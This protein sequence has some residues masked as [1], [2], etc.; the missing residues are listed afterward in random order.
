MKS[1][2]IEERYKVLNSEEEILNLF[3]KI[4]DS[5]FRQNYHIQ[6]ITGLLSD[7]NGFTFYNNKWH[8]FYQW[9]PW[10]AVHGLKYWYHVTSEDLVH[11]KNEGIGIKPDTFYDNKGA[12]SGSAFTDGNNLYLFY[13]GNHRDEDWVRTPYSCLAIYNDGKLEKLEEPLFGPR[14][15]YTEHQRDP[16]LIYDSENDKYYILIGAQDKNE[17]GSILVYTSDSF[18]K[19]WE[20]LGPLKIKG[21]ESIGGMYECPSLVLTEDKDILLFS[22]QYIKLP[23]RANSTNH[24]IYFIGKM[25]FDN[26]EF[27]P[28]KDYEFLDYGFDFYAAQTAYQ[29]NKDQDP[30]LIGWIGLPDNHYPSEEEDWEGSL[31]LPRELKIKDDILLQVPIETLSFLKDKEVTS[32]QLPKACKFEVEVLD[33]NNFYLNLFTQKDHSGGYQ[34]KYNAEEKLLEISKEH[35]IN[36]FNEE[37]GEKLAVYFENGIKNFDIFIDSN[38]V[39]IFFN[40][41]EKTFTAHIYPTKEEHYYEAS[42]N[43]NTKVWKLKS[44]NQNNFVI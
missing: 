7:P 36:R 21:I 38:S 43:L 24:S 19:D 9:C 2:T 1:W 5:D 40:G 12:H 27:I 37:I 16:K 28:D 17:K 25:D 8:L 32:H 15:D 11:W 23:D 20:F 18:E 34:I 44:S 26:L 10:G 39:E 14:P 6:P 3:N 29:S 13:T 22:P 31:S 41:G 4:K 35:L 42:S 33:D 30:I